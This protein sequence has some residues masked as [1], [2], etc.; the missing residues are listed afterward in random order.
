M[1]AA[2][3]HY[4]YYFPFFVSLSF[5]SFFS[6]FFLS[7]LFSFFFFLFFFDLSLESSVWVRA[8]VNMIC[9]SLLGAFFFS[10]AAGGYDRSRLL[11]PY[12]MTGYT[13]SLRYMAPEVKKRREGGSFLPPGKL[14]AARLLRRTHSGQTWG[15]FCS[16]AARGRGVSN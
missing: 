12:A 11:P 5:F 10:Q 6:F 9:G 4:Y 3:W 7:F 1:W 13:G 14:G 16:A 15:Y 8:S 2:P